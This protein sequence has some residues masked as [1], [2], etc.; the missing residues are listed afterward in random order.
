[1]ENS[2]F[3]NR[4][5]VYEVYKKKSFSKAAQS[6]Y[7]TQPCLSAIIIKLEKQIGVPL[8]DRSKKPIQLTEFGMKYIE[9]AENIQQLETSFK[10][11]LNDINQLKIGKV[12]IGANNVFASFVLPTLIH[13][14]SMQ[15]PNIK[16]DLIESNTA[17]LEE[18]LFSG[19]LD[20]VFD[21]YPLDDSIY[22]KDLFGEEHLILAVPEDLPVNKKLER[23]QLSLQ[24]IIGGKHL[25]DTVKAVPMSRFA[26]EPFIFLRHGNDTRIRADNICAQSKINPKIILELDQLATAYNVTCSGIGA[27]FI[28][29]TLAKK[30]K[31]TSPV[32]FYK[33]D[34]K[35]SSR[36]VY[37]YH[38]K[39]KYQT[40][41]VREFIRVA[42]SGNEKSGKL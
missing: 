16:V 26:K 7:I 20:I 37:F 30:M 28:S 17:N 36:P 5:Y 3:R 29:D 25:T 42:V 11:Y 14:F 19:N 22:D 38:K 40:I 32:V 6:L 15:F 33:I 13:M 9:Y 2:I 18:K 10:D 8:F 27:T 1:M 23:Y 31:I 24:D 39:S 41:A 21:N 12:A 4:D 35:E 34:S